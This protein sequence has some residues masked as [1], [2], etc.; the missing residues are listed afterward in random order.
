MESR[1]HMITISAYVKMA[2]AFT[3][4]QAITETKT[5]GNM[6][7]LMIRS[8]QWLKQVEAAR[9]GCALLH[10]GDNIHYRLT[11]LMERTYPDMVTVLE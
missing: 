6:K 4:P 7:R 5:R 9:R 2:T 11:R 10:V 1:V 8:A 3:R